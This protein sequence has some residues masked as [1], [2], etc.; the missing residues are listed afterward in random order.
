MLGNRKTRRYHSNILEPNQAYQHEIP[1]SKLKKKDLL[2]LCNDGTISA[3]SYTYYKSL[4]S[5]ASEDRLPE[6]DGEEVS[7]DDE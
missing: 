7:D 5:D 4:P 1:I 2:A 6:P 3:E